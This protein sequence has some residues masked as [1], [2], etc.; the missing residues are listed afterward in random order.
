MNG[1]PVVVKLGGTTIVEQQDILREIVEER[2]VRPLVIVHGGGKRL[3]DW[4]ERLGVESQWNG[5]RREAQGR[6]RY[7]RGPRYNRVNG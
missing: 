6:Q 4:L 1:T 7:G 2:Q 3:T 5:G